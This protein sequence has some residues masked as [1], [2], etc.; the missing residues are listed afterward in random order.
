MR[1]GCFI[2]GVLGSG[3]FRDLGWGRRWLGTISFVVASVCSIR[4][5]L[6]KRVFAGKYSVCTSFDASR[7]VFRVD[8]SAFGNGYVFVDCLES[9]SALKVSGNIII[10]VVYSSWKVH[11]QTLTSVFDILLLFARFLET[12]QTIRSIEPSH[13]CWG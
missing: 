1:Q 3:C 5:S 12:I 7:E 9:S 13:W 8:I 6:T 10:P 11:R 4:I 2:C